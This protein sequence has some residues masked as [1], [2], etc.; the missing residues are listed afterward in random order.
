MK[1][2]SGGMVEKRRLVILLEC[3][4]PFG[5]IEL[6]VKLKRYLIVAENVK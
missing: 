1:G 6:V 4:Q 5:L 2:H 3:I